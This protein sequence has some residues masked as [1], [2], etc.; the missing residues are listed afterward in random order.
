MST[1]IEKIETAKP[2]QAG[3]A[4]SQV[5]DAQPKQLVFE[6]LVTKKQL[7][8]SLS[9]SKSFINKLMANEGLPYRQLGRAVRFSVSEVADWL[10]TKRR[11]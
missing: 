10:H 7:A 2:S 6:N 4:K 11:P 1:P 5:V 9:I 8:E 3:N